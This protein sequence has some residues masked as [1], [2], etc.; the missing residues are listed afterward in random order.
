MNT[1]K[2]FIK[3]YKPYQGL[4]WMDMCCALTLS[5]IDLA[6]PLFVKF[7]MEDVYTLRNPEV[8]LNYTLVMGALLLGLYILK[9]FCQYF[10][11]SWGHIMGAKMEADMRRDLFGHLEKLS[12][13]YYD[14]TNTG[15]LMS[16]I[17]NDL[18]DISEL[19]HHGP[20]DVFISAIKLI[21]TFGILSFIN[22]K[23][24]AILLFFTLL[25]L[26]FSTTYNRRMRQ[27]FRINREK[28]ANVN[29]IAQDALGGIRVVKSFANE[30]QEMAKFEEGNAAF[31]ATKCD[32]Y[33][34]MGRFFSGNG[35][36]QGILYLAVVLAGGIFITQGSL[37]LID[38]TVY[39][40][41]I[42]TFLNPIEKLVNFTE[43]FQ[44]GMT[45]FERFLEIMNIHPDIQ[46]A[47]DAEELKEVKGTI[48]FEG[49]SFSYDDKEHVLS[50][51]DMHIP[52][53]KTIALV[54][55]SGGGKTTF[56]SLIPRFYEVS[57]GRI[58]LDGRDIRRL[59]QKSLR[60][61]IG[62]VQQDVYLFAGTVRENIAYG[63]QEATDEEII[64]AAKKAHIHDFVQS[65][66]HGYDTYIGERG[67]K[68]SGGQK[69]RLSIAR[70][71][72]KNPPL[73]ILDEATSALDN[74]S[75][76]FIQ[77][78]LNELAKNRTTL[79][80]AHRLSTIRHADEIVV[81]T[82]EGIKEKGSHETLLAKDGVYAYLYHMQF[83]Q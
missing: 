31:L 52:A 47:P 21:G 43:Q 32:S 71:F 13:S 1:L 58:T 30:E 26:I 70:V 63:K 57:E 22:Y 54:G 78:S 60:K 51:I 55:P 28:I 33:K 2:S 3:Y 65:L 12:F 27:V 37:Q 36:F 81:L 79:V 45:G 46:D 14:E 15:K 64:E 40:L 5:G 56:C 8:M 9:Y 16:R 73:L 19:A 17:V 48:Q 6:F 20:E 29:A 76:R 41:Y 75:E 11:T 4:F 34:I 23:L 62:I 18:F 24:T 53:G 35:F 39:I 50:Q 80:I 25:M 44:K 10:I 77:Q 66:P 7:L 59:T 83:E 38:L 61:A 72:L 74:E 49:V 68:L 69:Q 82:E 67:V 42:N